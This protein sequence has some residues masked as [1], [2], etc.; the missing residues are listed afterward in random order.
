MG[1]P[2]SLPKLLVPGCFASHSWGS[3]C[4]AGTGPGS[5][6][7]TEQ[8]LFS[9]GNSAGKGFGDISESGAV[10]NTGTGAL[11]ALSWPRCRGHSGPHHPYPLPCVWDLLPRPPGPT[12]DLDEVQRAPWQRL[13]RELQEACWA[14]RSLL[15][16]WCVGFGKEVMLHGLSASVQGRALKIL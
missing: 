11:G 12:G 8:G 10:P 6:P 13:G 4:A 1:K 9:M 7:P 16:S 5:H 14:L 2:Q 3:C 15:V